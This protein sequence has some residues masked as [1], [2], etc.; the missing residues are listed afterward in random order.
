MAP[1][2]QNLCHKS[3]FLSEKKQKK[4]QELKKRV[5]HRTAGEGKH[6]YFGKYVSHEG[7]ANLLTYEYHGVDNSLIYKYILTPMNNFL[8]TLLPLWLAPNLVSLVL[9]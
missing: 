7:S 9:L 1:S 8:V 4:L 5:R 6:M 3:S 2:S